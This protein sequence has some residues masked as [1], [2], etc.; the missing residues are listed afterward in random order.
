MSDRALRHRGF[1]G[2]P[3]VVHGSSSLF[4]DASG[5]SLKKGMTGCFVGH[6]KK[7]SF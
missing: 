5:F 3:V 4:A 2:D 6:F 7:V 1:M